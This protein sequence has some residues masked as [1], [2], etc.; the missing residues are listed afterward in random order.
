[1]VCALHVCAHFFLTQ[2][3]A[4]FS[5]GKL[6]DMLQQIEMF[7]KHNHHHWI[8]YFYCFGNLETVQHFVIDVPWKHFLYFRQYVWH[9]FVT[10]IQIWQY[11]Y[12]T[13]HTTYLI[14]CIPDITYNTCGI[15]HVCN[16]CEYQYVACVV[17]VTIIIHDIICDI[18]VTVSMP[19]HTCDIC[20][21]YLHLMLHTFCISILQCMKH[22][23]SQIWITRMQMIKH[24][25]N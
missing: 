23:T 3:F 21:V 2:Q 17:C 18:T 22:F 6:N 25:R 10:C 1:V 4:S 14:L 24:L 13:L 19:P 12:V 15:I 8:N 9:I 11:L 5:V 20:D 16:I 7:V